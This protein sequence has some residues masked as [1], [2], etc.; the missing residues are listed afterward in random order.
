MPELKDEVIISDIAITITSKDFITVM[1][2]HAR[3]VNILF[4]IFLNDE[5]YREYDESDRWIAV[6]QS[7]IVYTTAE[8][9]DIK[10]PEYLKR[11]RDAEYILLLQSQSK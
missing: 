7:R 9:Y 11:K 6:S 4:G 1:D 10:F 2:S 5:G 3:S 8:L